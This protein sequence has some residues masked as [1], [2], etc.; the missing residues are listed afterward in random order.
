MLE[1]P[2][3]SEIQ[4]ADCLRSSFHIAP[5]KIEFLPIGNDANSWVFRVETVTSPYFLKLKKGQ[6]YHPSLMVP[7]DLQKIGISQVLAPLPAQDGRLY[8]QVEPFNLIL[9][10]FIAGQNAMQKG[11]QPAQWAEFG[12]VLKQIHTAQLPLETGV[13]LQRE[14]FQLNPKCLKVAR[15]LNACLPKQAFSSASQLELAA[16]WAQKT[17]QIET[18]LNRAEE[19]GQMLQ[20]SHLGFVLC[21][22]DIHTANIMIDPQER[23]HIIDWDQPLLAPKER[24]LM[25]IGAIHE[26]GEPLSIEET[27]FYNGYGPVKLD[28]LAM[29]YYAYEWVV[30]EIGDFAERIF[31]TPN[32]NE[33]TRQDALRSFKQLF[34]PDDVI[35]GADRADRILVKNGGNY[36]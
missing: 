28:P 24:D 6:V 31:I 26:P 27:Y 34:D 9:Y 15:Q 35:D 16:L 32:F 30:Q 2:E 17:C 5:L 22:T 18:I 12:A 13:Q 4:I 7:F 25:F 21:H 36:F 23:M 11:M 3:I 10:P 20:Q 1:K 19:L 8:A 33:L 14:A 29:T